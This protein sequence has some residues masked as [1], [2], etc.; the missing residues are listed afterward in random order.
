MRHNNLLDTS[1]TGNPFHTLRACI[2]NIRTLGLYWW[3]RCAV[4]N[5][6]RSAGMKLP[7]KRV[8]GDELRRPSRQTG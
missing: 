5:A 6:V 4:E 7:R 2:W 3:L 1:L 8:E